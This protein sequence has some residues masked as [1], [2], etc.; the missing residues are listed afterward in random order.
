MSSLNLTE[1]RHLERVRQA[2]LERFTASSVVKWLTAKTFLRGKPF[3]FKGREY[4]KRILDD[5]SIEKVVKKP[6]QVGI[7][8]LTLRMA[9]AKANIIPYYTVAYTLPTAGFASTFVKTRLDPIIR[10][11]P[12]AKEALDPSLDNSE[13]KGFGSSYIYFKG[14][15]A[16]N[17]AISIPVDELLHDEIDFSD[18]EVLSQYE[19][20][21][22]ASPYK[23][24]TKLSTP[25][26]PDYGIDAEFK[27]SRRYFNF[28]K[29]NHCN[30]QFLPDY[31]KHVIVPDYTKHLDEIKKHHLPHIR[32]QEAKLL[33]P[34]CGK[35]PNMGPEHREWVLE[36]P[37]ENH[38]A[39][40]Y[41][42]Q[43]FDAPSIITIPSLIKTSTSYLLLKD[44]RNFGLGMTME[45][46][47]SMLSKEEMNALF[48]PAEAAG[49]TRVIGLDLGM[50]CRLLVGDVAEDESIVVVHAE[51]IPIGALRERV[52]ALSLAWNVSI[53]VSDSQPYTETIMGM[54]GNLQ[55]L[56]GAI[57]VRSKTMSLYNLKSVEEGTK[58]GEGLLRQVNINRDKGFDA[59]M[60]AI[61]GG[62]I[63]FKSNQEQVEIVSEHCDMKRVKIFDDSNEIVFTWKKSALGN[64]HYHHAGLYMFIAS[65][66]RGAAHI[67][68]PSS[69]LVSKF[70]I[71]HKLLNPADA[72]WDA[73][74]S[75]GWGKT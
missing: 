74:R 4:Q 10:E 52:A 59:Y 29:C 12:D 40:G 17:A 5:E 64:D 58:D 32:W 55:N 68:S 53:I 23:V 62:Q 22:T 25:T 14:C 67:T 56:W 26:L 38:V 35:E 34:S 9:L 47:D 3:S 46:S 7:S 6:S 49:H 28:V 63:R 19:S 27:A 48:A 57:Y 72:A 24:K 42:V 33:C 65:K 41:Q 73:L 30:H 66:M 2:A 16:G 75:K 31:Y 54:Q 50:T 8:E 45:D 18:P 39:V 51:R 69:F 70:V 44:F 11:C 13:V 1:S 21:I 60:G 43:P 15:A 71:P 20:R 61:R 37:D 36:N